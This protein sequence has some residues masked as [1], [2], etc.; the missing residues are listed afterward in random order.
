MGTITCKVVCAHTIYRLSWSPRTKILVPFPFLAG[1]GPCTSS[2]SVFNAGLWIPLL[3]NCVLL[4]HV[5]CIGLLVMSGIHY[6]QFSVK[7]EPNQDGMFTLMLDA[8]IRLQQQTGTDLRPLKHRKRL[9]QS[10]CVTQGKKKNAI[11]PGEG[12]SAEAF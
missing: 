6:V 8:R 10:I 2:S 3:Q 11:E 9:N 5:G 4:V 12:R 7:R 1:F